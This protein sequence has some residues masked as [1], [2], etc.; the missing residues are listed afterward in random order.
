MESH[1]ESA[2][3]TWSEP[4][5]PFTIEYTP[6]VLDDIRLAVVDA[7]FS[8]PR[9]GAEIGGILLGR[10]E[11][12]RVLIL[13][14]MALPCEHASGPSFVL[15][16]NDHAKLAEMLAVARGNPSAAQPVGWY[17]SHTRSEIC[18]SQADLEIHK[19]YFPEP[20]Q[21]A[22]VLKP[23]T[24]QPTKA[25]FFFRGQDGT[26]RETSCCREF[27]M[28]PLAVRPIPEAAAAAFVPDAPPAE[29]V[30]P[31]A[32]AA[33]PPALSAP[34]SRAAVRLWGFLLAAVLGLAFGAWAYYTRE[35][36]LPSVMS[37]VRPAPAPYVGLNTTD[38]GGQLQIR[39]DRNSPSVR[40]ARNG[41]LTIGDGP[42]PEAIEL[43][44]IHLQTGVFTY[45]RKGARIDVAMTLN[46][47]DGQKVREA[48]TYLGTAP[49]SKP[50]LDDSALRKERDDLARSLELER[51]RSRKLEK[52]LQKTHRKR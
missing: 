20:W 31:D 26:I 24:F 17:H 37:V 3:A 21:V 27:D 41:I 40:G 25:G 2:L 52:Q 28:E 12:G 14:Y 47:P 36:W 44:P 38:A 9:G 30:A 46:E 13:D 35:L 15:S 11:K 18:L 10:H 4:S 45:A 39:W 1:T 5:C 33:R 50:T 19:R 34:A 7:F 51:A 6:R 22:L 48:T 32:P 23:H 43:D 16:P 29:D 42:V 8:L 49:E